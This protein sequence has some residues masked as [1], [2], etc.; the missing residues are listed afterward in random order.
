MNRKKREIYKNLPPRNDPHYMKLYREKRNLKIW[1]KERL[2]EKVAGDPDYWKKKYNPI[3]AKKSRT[4][5]IR[6]ISE[7]NWKRQGIIEFTYIQ[8]LRILEQQLNLCKICKRTMNPPHVDHCHK[9]GKFRSLLCTR[10]NLGL[11]VYESRKEEFE[12]YLDN[13]LT[14]TR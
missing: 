10:C 2:K 11:G 3:K 1:E 6:S 13:I 8:Y 5:N 7:S 4:R 12:K 14:S 9:T